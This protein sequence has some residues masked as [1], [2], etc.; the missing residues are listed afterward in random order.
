MFQIRILKNEPSFYQNID[1]LAET[2]TSSFELL[3]FSRDTYPTR[4]FYFGNDSRSDIQT[5]LNTIA[6]KSEVTHMPEKNQE[7]W[8]LPDSQIETFNKYRKKFQLP[9]A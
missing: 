4:P 6:E 3:H 2:I 1:E 9:P 5:L 7:L 8:R